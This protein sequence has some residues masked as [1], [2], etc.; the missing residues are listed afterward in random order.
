MFLTEWVQVIAGCRS[1]P[2]RVTLMENM[3]SLHPIVKSPTSAWKISL[4]TTTMYVFH[5]HFFHFLLTATNV[6]IF[7]LM[8]WFQFQFYFDG[9]HANFNIQLSKP[10]WKTCLRIASYIFLP[11]LL[12][13]PFNNYCSSLFARAELALNA[14][15]VVFVLFVFVVCSNTTHTIFIPSVCLLFLKDFV[16][17]RFCHVCPVSVCCDTSAF[18]N[19]PLLTFG[20]VSHIFTNSQNSLRFK[21]FQ[22]TRSLGMFLPLLEPDKWE[23]FHIENDKR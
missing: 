3:L 14:L 9:K 18:R 7:P 13:I 23:G 1:S 5:F 12:S 15:V 20:D 17:C 4:R 2:L 8:S 21:K 16:S 6:C 22:V 19:F 11:F 10:A